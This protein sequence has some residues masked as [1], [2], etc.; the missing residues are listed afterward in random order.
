[1]AAM[2]PS[3]WTFLE[4]AL[5]AIA[6]FYLLFVLFFKLEVADEESAN[7]ALISFSSFLPIIAV[8]VIGLIIYLFSFR[9]VNIRHNI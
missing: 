4:N 2:N 7:N 9:L 5:I 3:K 8:K 1:M 6:F